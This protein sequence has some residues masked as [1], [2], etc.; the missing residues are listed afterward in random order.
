M[1][2]VITL[3]NIRK[4][5]GKRTILDNISFSVSQGDI[6]G[7]LGPNGAGKTTTM[8][9][10]LGLLNPDSG[11]VSVNG[12]DLFHDSAARS[13][14]GVLL[15]RDGLYDRISAIDNLYYYAR[16]YSVNG[17]EKKID[18]ML[19]FT[20]LTDRKYDKVGNYSKGMK[21]KLGLTRALIHEPEVLFLDEPSAGL[22]P[23]AQKMVRDLLLR[24]S[25]ERQMT[26]F[27]NSHDL[28]EVQRICSKVA[29]IQKGRILACDTLEKLKGNPEETI[30]KITFTD[31]VQTEKAHELMEELDF[32]S[33]RSQESKVSL[34][35]SLSTGKRS[36]DLLACLVGKE[37]GVEEISTEKQSL[38]DIYIEIMHQEDK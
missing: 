5:M 37:I 9:V 6:F 2:E 26:I 1:A 16:L 33:F 3:E 35:A 29:I 24:L 17:L 4:E 31:S 13:R 14:I 10:I 28:D 34:T 23:E 21:R 27:L 19:E 22:D 18:D 15:D 7:Y 30:V 12:K 38:E 11:K 8:R 36:S 20:G 25:T 32:V